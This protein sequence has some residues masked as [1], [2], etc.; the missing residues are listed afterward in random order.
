MSGIKV[1][2]NDYVRV[3]LTH[4]GRKLLIKRGFVPPLGESNVVETQLWYLFGK[5]AEDFQTPHLGSV[6]EHAE[7]EV[8]TEKCAWCLAKRA[9]EVDGKFCSENCKL[10]HYLVETERLKGLK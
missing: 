4:R 1:R 7:I 6:F 2:L 8:F 5:V 10:S 3:T 9:L